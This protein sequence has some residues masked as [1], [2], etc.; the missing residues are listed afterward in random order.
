MEA[1]LA[2]QLGWCHYIRILYHKFLVAKMPILHSYP[3]SYSHLMLFWSQ[4]WL[5]DSPTLLSDVI[6]V[7]CVH[8]WWQ[9]MHADAMASSLYAELADY[10]Y[11]ALVSMDGTGEISL[12]RS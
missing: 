3:Q 10:A 4:D 5:P 9:C 1:E 12:S 7:C 8:V 2:D 6:C 11:E